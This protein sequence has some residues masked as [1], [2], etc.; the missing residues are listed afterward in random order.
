[1]IDPVKREVLRAAAL[2]RSEIFDARR[3][4]GDYDRV[5]REAARG[6]KAG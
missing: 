3:L 5:Y 4:V 2:N 1:M 6:S